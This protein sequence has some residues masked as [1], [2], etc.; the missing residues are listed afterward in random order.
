MSDYINI[1]VNVNGLNTVIKKPQTVKL[2][3]KRSS[4]HIFST[5]K[6]FTLNINMQI[7]E[8]FSKKQKT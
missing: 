6:K 2:Y 1:T 5:K 4:D 7:G 8:S 3:R